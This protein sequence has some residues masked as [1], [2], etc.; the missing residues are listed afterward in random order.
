MTESQK[1]LLGIYLESR[2][3]RIKATFASRAAA[4]KEAARLT[5]VKRN[6]RISAYKCK[7]CA[8]YHTGH[9]KF[10]NVA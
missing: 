1:E 3:C 10:A 8:G 6:G 9:N 5:K 4:K 2:S 7:Y